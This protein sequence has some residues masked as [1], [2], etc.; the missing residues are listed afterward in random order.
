MEYLGTILGDWDDVTVAG[1]GDLDEVLLG[2]T[3]L[4]DQLRH[5]PS[6]SVRLL[7]SGP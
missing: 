6:F 4:R 1:V 7:M 2:N 5:F 3:K